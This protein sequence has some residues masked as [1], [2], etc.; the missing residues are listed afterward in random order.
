MEQRCDGNS[1]RSFPRVST[2]ELLFI[3][4]NSCFDTWET[5]G[6]HFFEC[7]ECFFVFKKHYLVVD[8]S[9]AES[10]SIGVKG[11]LLSLAFRLG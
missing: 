8:L 3:T 7:L 5:L 10:Y 9:K 1:M 11:L 6:V 4:G 2:L